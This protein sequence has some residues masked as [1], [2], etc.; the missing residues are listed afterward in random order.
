MRVGLSGRHTQIWVD[1][2]SAGRLPSE[3]LAEQMQ[4]AVAKEARIVIRVAIVE[5]DAQTRAR[6]CEVIGAAEDIELVGVA[7]TAA[8]GRALIETGGY[9]VLLCD[10][11][12]PDGDGVDLIR[13]EA[14]L[15]RNVDI[16]VVTLFADQG[17]VL[18]TIRAGARGYVLKDETLN[19]C[20]E[21][22]RAIRAGGSPISPIIARQLLNQVDLGASDQEAPRTRLTSR[23]LE[24]LN[25]L[26]R[27]FSY[28]EC[29]EILG[30][31]VATVGAHV[32]NIY[33]KL[34]VNSR[35]EALFEATQQ[36]LLKR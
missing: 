1:H 26:A 22:I 30:L 17:K 15:Q 24:L 6:L 18:D 13:A 29:A 33:R 32:K 10:L 27:G 14:N 16:M 28:A 8:D 19:E 11:G 4:F 20:V 2:Q 3:P 7:A 9:E 34:E 36:G 12:L 35:A 5:D 21:A 23:E 25:I 31:A